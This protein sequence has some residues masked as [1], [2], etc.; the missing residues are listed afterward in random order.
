[1]NTQLR[2]HLRDHATRAYLGTGL[3]NYRWARGKL[4]GDAIFPALLE[5][6]VFR[7]GARVLDLG[8]GRGLLAAWFLAAEQMAAR[9]VWPAHLRQPPRDLRF[10]G[11]ELMAREAEVGNRALQPHFPGR[12]ELCGGDMCEAPVAGADAVAILD[13]LHYVDFPAQE[14]L[15]DRIRDALPPGGVLITRVGD[16]AAGWRFRFSQF[17]DRCMAGAQ[18]HAAPPT[19]CRPLAAW[20]AALESRGFAVT[21][22]S[23]SQGTPFANVMLVG[24]LPG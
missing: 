12:V 11:F 3:F 19:W 6:N 10:R 1:M 13:V 21:T 22:A 15:L 23:M 20:V 16:A 18:G 9:G 8:C 24:R 17:V 5:A 2:R 4:G 14:K 7:D